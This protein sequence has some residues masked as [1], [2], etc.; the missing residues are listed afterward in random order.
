MPWARLD[1]G[2]WRNTKLEAVSLAALGLYA[3][4]LSY[5]G[6]Q[7]TDGKISERRARDLARG[8]RSLIDELV[9]CGLWTV[10]AGGYVIRDFLDYNPSAEEW[11]NL[12]E[13]RAAAGRLGG[14]AK[15]RKRGKR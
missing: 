3:L 13:R 8:R 15:A 12:S 2:F 11:A 1:D 6:D 9:N 10:E 7:T 14:L 4:G 5:A